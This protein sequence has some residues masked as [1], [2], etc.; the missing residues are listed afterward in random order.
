MLQ[1]MATT[2]RWGCWWYGGIRISDSNHTI[3]NNY[4]QDCI[5]VASQAKW[6][7]GITFIGGGD[8]AAIDCTATGVTN[9]Y[10]KSE[11]INLANNTIIN[12]NAPLFYNSDK[13]ST[14]P[15]G[16]V[17]NNLIYFAAANP[18]LSDVI[19]GDTSTAYA[20]MGTAL[21]YSGNVFNG[22]ALGETNSG[23]SE[24]PGIM[25]TANGETF[26][27]SGTGSAGKGADMGVYTP[28]T[29]DMVGYGIGACFLNNLGANIGDGNCT[30]VIGEYLTVSSLATLNSV[31]ANYDVSVTANV[32]WTAVSNDAW[33]TIDTNSGTDN[34][35]V[36][37]TV[38]EN[39]NTSSRTG[40]VTFT[41][42]AGGDD[43][44]R[45]LNITQEGANL[46]DLYDLINTGEA[47]D[48]VTINSFSKEEVDEITKFNYAAN[49]LDKD[50]STV[51]A[52]DDGA[53]LSGDYKGDGEYIIY[54]LGSD[55]NLDLVQFSTTNKS[56]AFGFQ[57]WVST[58]G[59]EV[60]D[61]RWYY[62]L[63]VIC[64]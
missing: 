23:F 57:V 2:F 60:S 12:T 9:G 63:L 43:I 31:G 7:N 40:T 14:D 59:T 30:I 25:A 54:D 45:T 64:C 24:E 41:Q 44:V 42:D 39:T 58:T 16:T 22:T 19:S 61:F 10:Q 33:I 18:N 11:N 26:T 46:T 34:A 52:A 47:S 15:T 55:H 35:T 53:I 4:I 28:T 51:W 38:S 21:S 20:D 6:N 29:D 48:P 3:T 56:D 17:S 50:N 32:S 36:S 49:T 37:V 5:T 62:L 27:F 8:N 13:G 1:L